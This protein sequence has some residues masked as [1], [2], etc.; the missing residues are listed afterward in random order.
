MTPPSPGI[1]VDFKCHFHCH[2]DV[3]CFLY[4]TWQKSTSD[5]NGS[6]SLDVAF[7]WH[8]HSSRLIN[9]WGSSSCVSQPGELLILAWLTSSSS[10]CCRNDCQ[11]GFGLPLIVLPCHD[12]SMPRSCA[13][14]AKSVLTSSLQTNL[15]SS[16]SIL[17]RKAI[18]VRLPWHVSSSMMRWFPCRSHAMRMAEQLSM[19]SA[20]IL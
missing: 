8:M 3:I 6:L 13:L 2:L 17:A 18:H 5:S 20:G 9:D 7:H 10:P 12:T 15:K 4:K 14:D 19:L 11:A 16:T 1:N